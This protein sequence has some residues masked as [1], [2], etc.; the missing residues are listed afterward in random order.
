MSGRVNT[1]FVIGLSATLV[2]IIVGLVGVWYM[3]VRTDP[4]EYIARANA[5]LDRGQYA[6]AVDYYRKAR[7]G[8]P[9]STDLMLKQAKAMSQIT[10]ED[11]R[12]ARA[13]IGQLLDLYKSVLDVDSRNEEAMRS[14]GGIYMQIGRELGDLDAWDQLFKI[15]NTAVLSDPGNVL[16]KQYRGIAQVNRMMA[17]NVSDSDV[18]TAWEDLQKAHAADGDDP[19]VTHHMALWHVIQFKSLL[20]IAGNPT[21]AAEHQKQ[22][23]ALSDELLGKY[24][25]EPRIKVYKLRV[26]SEMRMTQEA[27]TLALEL[28]KLLVSNPGAADIVLEVARQLASRATGDNQQVKLDTQSMGRALDLVTAAAQEHPADLRLALL[29]GQILTV[30]SKY[31][32]ALTVLDAAS[33]N[34]HRALPLVAYQSAQLRRAAAV[35]FADL[36][37]RQADRKTGEVRETELAEVEVLIE[38]M[39]ADTGES[40]YVSMLSGKLNLTRGNWGLALKQLDSASS[41]FND[42]KPDILLLSASACAQLGELGAA[43]QRLETLLKVRGDYMPARLELAKLQ[44]RLSQPQQAKAE[45]DI[46]LRQEGDNPSLKTQQ[47]L[48]IYYAQTDQTD[49]AIALYQRLDPNNDLQVAMS[50]ARL[51]ASNGQKQQAVNLLTH[52]FNKTPKNV[53]V[54]RE[55]VEV[56]ADARQLEP[57]FAKAQA[58]GADINALTLLKSKLT[59]KT[60][61]SA[62]SAAT[63]IVDNIDD[64]FERAM[65]QYTLNRQLGKTDLADTA[66]REASRLKPDHPRVMEVLF[67]QSI[68]QKDWDKAQQLASKARTQNTDL[69]EGTLF[70]GRLDLA[71]GNIASAVT[72]LSRGMKQRPVYSEGWRWLAQA[73]RA[74]GDI[75]AAVYSYQESIRQRPDNLRAYQGLADAFDAGSRTD[76]ALRIWRQ[77]FQIAPGNRFYREKYLAYE[78]AKG[79]PSKALAVRQE[80]AQDE[81][82]DL[83]NLRGVAVLLAHL[84]KMDQAAVVCQQLFA[85]APSDRANYGAYAAVLAINNQLDAARAVLDNYIKQLGSKA[86]ADDFML[87]AR[88]LVS[89]D[90]KAGAFEQYRNAVKVDRSPDMQASRELADALFADSRFSQAAKVYQQVWEKDRQDGRVGYRLVETLQRNR[91]YDSAGSVLR[92]LEQAIGKSATSLLLKAQIARSQDRTSEAVKHLNEAI[93]LTPDDAMVYYQRASMLMNDPD[94]ENRVIDDLRKVLELDTHFTAAHR[95]LAQIHLR[96]DSFDQAVRE[97]ESV[98][99]QN[100]NDTSTRI[101]LLQM[102]IGIN[103]L[104]AAKTMLSEAT[105]RFPTESRWPKLQADLAIREKNHR[106]ASKYLLYAFELEPDD[107]VLAA[108]GLEMIQA[109][110]AGMAIS[111]IEQNPQMLASNVQLRAILGR[112]KYKVGRHAEGQVEF[113]TALR[114]AQS[115]N[116]VTNVCDQLA[117]SRGLEQTRSMLETFRGAKSD[118]WLQIA[119]ART[120]VGASKYEEAVNRLNRIKPQIGDKEKAEFTGLLSLALH[121]SGKFEEAAQ[122]YQQVLTEDPKSVAALNNLAYL[123]ATNLNRPA[124]ALKYAQ[125]ASAMAPNDPQVLDTLGWVQF[126]AGDIQKAQVTLRRSVRIKPFTA[127]TYHLAEVMLKDGQTRYATELLDMARQLAQQNDDKQMLEKVNVRI[128]EVT[129]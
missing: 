107:R 100:P 28:E 53:G 109:D 129:Q 71:R 102:Y 94:Q 41:Q 125:Q 80:I 85:K 99:S 6:Q 127:N 73:Q 123:L 89:V 74:A 21:K 47:L 13:A 82:D 118:I 103:D 75:A 83:G 35:Q 42:R 119:I 78:Q 95:M 1:K 30:M 64:P 25:D 39:R 84:K 81:P 31:D 113:E 52:H 126:L 115:L 4:A 104:L 61:M 54:L 32:Q 112:A 55:L 59:D 15:T 101:E 50:L 77:V 96:H 34:S 67:E 40:A 43:V 46:V 116:D 44:L 33:N 128:K 29:Q 63:R 70:A 114:Q 108:M 91:E 68:E 97:Y 23:L 117:M 38:K 106:M 120:L 5:M 8:R 36:K 12:Q 110:A 88:F 93:A 105:R 111:K 66:L 49:K 124:E 79:D 48:A 26:L 58:S 72:M 11:S 65:S 122:V 121:N 76:D 37:L 56:V 69:A 16:A 60:G 57:Y 45:I 17:I 27:E 18:K 92:R 9:H 51:Q 24:P 14:L 62:V 19:D 3:F 90:D 22:A 2:A 87:Y 86:V 10:V 98:L 20:G 7:S